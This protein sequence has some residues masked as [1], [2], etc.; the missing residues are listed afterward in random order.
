G[1]VRFT[2]A[3]LVNNAYTPAKYEWED[4]TGDA[5]AVERGMAWLANNPGFVRSEKPNYN[6]NQQQN[7]QASAP[8]AQNGFGNNT[9]APG[10]QAAQGYQPNQQQPTSAPAANQEWKPQEW[11]PQEWTP[12]NTSGPAQ[13]LEQQRQFGNQ[14]QEPPS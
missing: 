9:W 4:F 1:R 13:N 6:T 3:T 10:N 11:K 14:N 7:Q 12:A 8:P 2:P 5:K